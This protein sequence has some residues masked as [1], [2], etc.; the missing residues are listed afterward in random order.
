VGAFDTLPCATI[1]DCLRDAGIA[2]L[3]TT[4]HMDVTITLSDSTELH[5]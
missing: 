4:V 5:T 1:I 2:S 3:I